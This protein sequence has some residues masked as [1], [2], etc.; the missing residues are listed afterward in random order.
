MAEDTPAQ[1][2]AAS[3]Q[4]F[5]IQ[6]LYVKDVSFEAPSSPEV[7]LTEWKGETNVQLHTESHRLDDLTHEVSLTVTVTTKSND[8]TAYLVEVKQAGVFTAKGFERDT[9]GHLLG[10][11]CPTLLFPYVREAISSLVLKGGFPDIQLAPVN[12]DRLYLQH[13]E[14]LKKQPPERGTAAH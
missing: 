1:S 9:L 6:K 13:L 14:Q 8:K 11:Y 7:F 10:A 2:G 4:E 5:A 3:A 12:F